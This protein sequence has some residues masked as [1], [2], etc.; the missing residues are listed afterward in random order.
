MLFLCALGEI[1]G[2]RIWFLACGHSGRQVDNNILLGYQG[3]LPFH[4]LTDSPKKRI[5]AD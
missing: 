4:L 2:E 1:C 5:V 3:I